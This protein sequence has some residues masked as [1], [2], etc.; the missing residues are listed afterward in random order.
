ML[1]APHRPEPSRAGRFAGPVGQ[2]PDQPVPMGGTAQS[3]IRL[4]LGR[5]HRDPATSIDVRPLS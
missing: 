2:A 3:G 5:D 1:L 4:P